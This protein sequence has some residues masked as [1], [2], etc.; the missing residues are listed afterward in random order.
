MKVHL[1]WYEPYRYEPLELVG[2]YHD[3]VDGRA[4]RDE[5]LRSLQG[6]GFAKEMEVQGE[7]EA[8]SLLARYGVDEA[9]R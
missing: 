8:P 6:R 4:L 2:I 9:R 1:V 5:E 7:L 3:T